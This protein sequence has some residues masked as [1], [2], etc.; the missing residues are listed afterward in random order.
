MSGP[1][2]LDVRLP[3]GG[4][5]AALGLILAGYGAVG[6]RAEAAGP[7]VPTVNLNLWW[8]LTMLLFGL[9]LLAAARYAVKKAGVRSAVASAEGRAIETRERKEG[10]EM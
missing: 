9:A 10:L 7:G 6:G 8:G 3:L 2:G 5:F 4:V 1:V